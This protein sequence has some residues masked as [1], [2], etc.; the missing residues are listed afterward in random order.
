MT[1][2][3]FCFYLQNRQ[4]Q[5]SQTGGQWYSDTSPFSIP[6]SNTLAYFPDGQGQTFFFLQQLPQRIKS[7]GSEIF[8]GKRKRRFA[9]YNLMLG[10][11]LW[12]LPRASTIKHCGLVI[13][14]KGTDF[15][16]S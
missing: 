15:V 14:G 2:D 12:K 4:I 7:H 5:T 13:Y 1:T 8:N 11:S 16:V 10:R 6:W 9:E 3:N